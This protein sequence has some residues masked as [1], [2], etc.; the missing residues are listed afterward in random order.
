MWPFVPLLEAL[1]LF[2]VDGGGQGEDS[3]TT[4]V[5]HVLA[6]R[7]VLVFPEGAR[8][9]NR[10]LR[11]RSGGARIALGARA[12]LVPAAVHGTEQASPFKRWH[13]A[14]GPP[15]PLDDLG[16]MP[17][18]AAAREATRRVWNQVLALEAALERR[19]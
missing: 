13:V 14:F 15:T 18:A 17:T 9:R 12:P 16:S 19:P 8:R 11:P 2:P 4:A 5:R 10:V 6:G 3:V 7:I 1:G